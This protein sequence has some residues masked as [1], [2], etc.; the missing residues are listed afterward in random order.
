[1]IFQRRERFW[2]CDPQTHV[3]RKWE[4]VSGDMREKTN[5]TFPKTSLDT[6]GV[7]GCF[8]AEDTLL[9]KNETSDIYLCPDLHDAPC[10]N[11]EIFGRIRRRS[12]QQDEQFI[13][14]QRHVGA[15]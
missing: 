7:P 2:K 5:R 10:R 4:P 3:S 1:M 6:K 13:L 9:I 14:P 11:L 12:C 8:L 15:R